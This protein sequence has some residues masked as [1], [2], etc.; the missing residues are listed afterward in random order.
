MTKITLILALI[1]SIYS[2]G[3]SQEINAPFRLKV[4]IDE[5]HSDSTKLVTLKVCNNSFKTYFVSDHPPNST[6]LNDSLCGFSLNYS[7]SYSD[8]LVTPYIILELWKLSPFKCF[9]VDKVKKSDYLKTVFVDFDFYAKS[10]VKKFD[11]DLDKVKR[12][13]KYALTVEEYFVD[14]F[15]KTEVNSFLSYKINLKE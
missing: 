11:I 8:P 7:N 12:K 10:T 15:F 5:N 9:E 13:N 14:L 4:K 6:Y 1:L 2:V 3:I